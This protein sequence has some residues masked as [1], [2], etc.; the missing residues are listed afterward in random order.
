[1]SGDTIT[2]ITVVATDSSPS[3]VLT[4][5]DGGTL[6]P[7]LSVD[8][9]T[10]VISGTPT[11]AG[12]YPVTV[13][14]TDDSGSTGTATFTWTVTDTVTVTGTSDLTTVSG[15]PI[16]PVTPTGTDSSP[17]ASVTAW[18]ATGLPAGL[19]IDHATGAISGTPTTAGTTAVTVTATDSAHF[20]GSASFTWTVTNTVTFGA[21][22]DQSSHVGTAVTAVHATA[23][24][25][26]STTALTYSA[27]GLPAGLT[28]APSTGTISGTPTRSGVTSVVVTAIDGAGFSGTASFTWTVVGPVI[29][30]ITPATGPASGGTKV[31]IVGTGLNGATSVTF[32]GVAATSVK[33]AKNGLKL[34]VRTPAHLAGPV[35]VV[36]TTSAGPS[37]AGPSTVFTYTPPTVTSLSVTT[38]P[39]TGGTTVKINGTGFTGAT[40]VHF[41]AAPA[42]TIKVNA[43]G[44][45]VTVKAPPGST[46]TV[47]VTVTT[48]EGTSATG[49]A[50]HFTYG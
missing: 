40:A 25:S 42:A 44:T 6:P 21:I 24:D 37:L 19:A 34:K 27:T 31:T 11:T 10:G 47:D 39:A 2:P 3:A 41:G 26:S 14:A 17:T 4:F 33:A 16:T 46:G 28:I 50:D 8:A 48:P 22:A 29:T 1:V 20:S 5:S 13:T 12:V 43:K 38:G 35:Q 23:T 30:S 45:Q 7:G 15:S 36:V 9:A 49:P 32:G 18:A